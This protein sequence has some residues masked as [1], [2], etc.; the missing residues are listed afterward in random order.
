MAIGRARSLFKNR[1]FLFFQVNILDKTDR[2]K[3]E[4]D[5]LK[6]WADCANPQIYPAVLT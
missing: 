5:A 1:L 4:K 2:L 3:G 6:V